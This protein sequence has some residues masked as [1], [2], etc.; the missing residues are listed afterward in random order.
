MI[1]DAMFVYTQ[2][3][4]IEVRGYPFVNGQPT[5]IRDGATLAAL[6]KRPDFKRI[7]DEEV[8]E[9][10]TAEEVLGVERPVLHA[11]RGWPL[12]KPRK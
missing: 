9:Q 11:K 5:R 6:S 7:D 4:Y 8:K 1:V 12:G 3:P 2:G 10:A